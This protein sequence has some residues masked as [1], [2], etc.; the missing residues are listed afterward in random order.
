V[1]AAAASAVAHLPLVLL[2]QLCIWPYELQMVA[3]LG[4]Q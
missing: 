1:A 3:D 2:L 4:Q